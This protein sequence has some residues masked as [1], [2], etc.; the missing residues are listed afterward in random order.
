M[1]TIDQSDIKSRILASR[2][3]LTPV[4]STSL[5]DRMGKGAAG[6]VTAGGKSFS[7]L[8]KLKTKEELKFS[9]HAASRLKSRGIEVTPE[10]MGKLEKAVEGAEGKGARDTLVMVKDLAFIVN[11]PNRTIITAMDGESVKDNIFTNID[12]TVIAG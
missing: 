8:L 11:I 3:G 4:T 5:G 10:T 2:A 7:D 9:A 1:N 6:A 12:S